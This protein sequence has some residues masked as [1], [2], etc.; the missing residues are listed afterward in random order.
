MVK[1]FFYTA[2]L[3]AATLV[4]AHPGQSEE[5]LRAELEAVNAYIGTLDNANLANC[6]PKFTKRGLD[7]QNQLQTVVNRRLDKVKA[8]RRDLGLAEDGKWTCYACSRMRSD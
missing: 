4:Q 3:A 1:L 8:L 6:V 2:A 5:S 7:G